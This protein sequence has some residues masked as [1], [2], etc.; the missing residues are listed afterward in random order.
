MRFRYIAT[1]LLLLVVA[2]SWGAIFAVT[3]D[4][5]EPGDH[6]LP[7]AASESGIVR[8]AGA[9]ETNLWAAAQKAGMDFELLSDFTEIFAWQLDFERQVREGDRFRLSVERLVEPGRPPRW[10]AILAAEY[11][12]RGGRHTAVRYEMGGRARYFRPDGSSLKQRFLRSP[13]R[14]SHVSSGFQARRYHPVLR[15]TRPHNGIDYAARPG[16]PVMA[17]AAGVVSE[18]GYRGDAGRMVAIK[19]DSLHAT[20][21]LHLS[22]IAVAVKPGARVKMGQVIGYVGSSGLATGPHLH[23]ELRYGGRV[24]DPAGMRFP[25]APGVPAAEKAGFDEVAV[26]RLATLPKWPEATASTPQQEPGEAQ[27]L[28]AL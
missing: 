3:F 8:F 23:F 25:L 6:Q 4:L 12:A 11:E 5:D 28:Q 10:G 16:T 17:I 15:I 19:H 2:S 13:L 21:Y 9:V 22:R 1:C 18:A 14:Y 27:A 7:L 20:A 26:E 24:V